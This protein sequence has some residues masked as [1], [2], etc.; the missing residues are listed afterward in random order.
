M[1]AVQ[2]QCAVVLRL[3]EN[4]LA[5]MEF[6]GVD[7]R[8]FRADPFR[9][10]RLAQSVLEPLPVFSAAFLA[11]AGAWE[12]ALGFGRSAEFAEVVTEG[13]SL[14]VAGARYLARGLNDS[15]ALG[16]VLAL[17]HALLRGEV[18]AGAGAPQAEVALSG[19]VALLALPVGTLEHHAA[20]LALVRSIDAATQWER[21]WGASRWSVPLPVVGEAKEEVLIVHHE[22]GNV[23]A[24]LVSAELGGL[25][26]LCASGATVEAVRSHLIAELEADGADELVADLVQDRLL[27]R[28]RP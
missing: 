19:S 2:M 10:P 5:G 16:A 12:F 24:E 3:F 9:A 1:D 8:A 26:R 22:A 13:A 7:P 20:G 4:P 17:E 23:T 14:P 18:G 6:P 28:V 11:R 15:I 25:L 21:I 27:R